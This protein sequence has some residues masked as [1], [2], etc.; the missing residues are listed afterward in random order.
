MPA[1]AVRT[2][3]ELFTVFSGSGR[4]C[5]RALVEGLGK[6]LAI[7]DTE[8]GPG[9]SAVNWAGFVTEGPGLTNDH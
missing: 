5:K 1:R 8:R 2:L 6:S 4:R 3:G 9:A 7:S